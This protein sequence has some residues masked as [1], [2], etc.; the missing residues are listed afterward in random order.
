M[1][2]ERIDEALAA[3]ALEDGARA[4]PQFADMKPRIEVVKLFRGSTLQVKFG[5]DKRQQ[6]DPDNFAYEKV[7]LKTY[8]ALAGGRL[9]TT[10]GARSTSCWTSCGPP[11]AAS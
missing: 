10:I 7:V 8:R 3:R 9:G 6:G 11:I 4:F 1:D 2:E 5:D